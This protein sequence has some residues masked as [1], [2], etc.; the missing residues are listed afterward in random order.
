MDKDNSLSVCIVTYNEEDNIRGCLESVSWAEEI[1]VVDSLSNDRTTEICREYTDRVIQRKWNGYIDQKSFALK[2]A[3][4]EWVL[5]IDADERLSPGLIEEIK[6]EISK[7]NNE[8]DGFYLARHIYYLGRWIN[9]GEWYP[10]YRLR[11]FK[12][13]KGC[14]GGIEPHDKVELTAAGRVRVKYLKGNM[15][16]FTYKNISAQIR[17]INK[18]SSISAEE[19][20]KT[21]KNFHIFRLLF[22]PPAR[23]ITGYILRGGFKDGIPG[24]IIAVTCSFH[25]FL[26]YCKLWE[27]KKKK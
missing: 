9:H 5:F 4:G 11:L 19:M 7:E 14:I 27:L 16:H 10:E 25:V 3:S 6:E 15:H 17:T 2:Q 20:N 8:Y 18:F 23:F 22:H 21:G 26:K 13:S 24:L 12:R 1:I